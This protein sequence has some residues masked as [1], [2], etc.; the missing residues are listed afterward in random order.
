VFD[1]KIKERLLPRIGPDSSDGFWQGR[2]DVL[3]GDHARKGAGVDVRAHSSKTGKHKGWAS[4]GTCGTR[5]R[6][7]A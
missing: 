4:T 6:P 5:R 7:T 3:A 1:I 2:F